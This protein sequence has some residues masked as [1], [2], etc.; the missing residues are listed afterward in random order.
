MAWN[1]QAVA[2]VAGR[3]LNEEL[4]RTRALLR[5][6]DIYGAWCVCAERSEHAKPPDPT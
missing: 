1:G 5:G 4:G 3:G 6:D 2:A